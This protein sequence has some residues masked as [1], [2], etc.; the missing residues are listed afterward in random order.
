L[1]NRDNLLFLFLIVVHLI[2]LWAYQYFP[3]QDGPAH[4][5]NATIIRPRHRLAAVQSDRP[6]QGEGARRTAGAVQADAG[7]AVKRSTPGSTDPWNGG[8]LAPEKT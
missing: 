5:A 7:K 1:T 3:S 2:P 8:T 6:E 4:L